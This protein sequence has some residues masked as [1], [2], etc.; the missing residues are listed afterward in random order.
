MKRNYIVL[1]KPEK[2]LTTISTPGTRKFIAKGKS[3]T[4]KGVKQ[5][6]A[7]SMRVESLEASKV[8]DVSAKKD[9]E[10]VIPAMPMK[11]MKPFKVNAPAKPTAQNNTWGVEATLAHKSPFNG[12][13][14][15]VAVLDTGINANHPAFKGVNFITE[16]FTGEGVAD[17]DGHGT[18]C[19]GT[20]CGRDVNGTRIGIAPG[21]TDMLIG[22]VIGNEGGS[23]TSIA[24]AINWALKNQ[25]NVISLSLGI[26]FPG[27]VVELQGEGM[28]TDI[29][30]SK[31]LEGYRANI[32]LFEK[33]AAFVK[34]L[35]LFGSATVLVAAAGNESR[36]EAGEDFEIAVSPPAVSEGFISV[37]ALGL[38][39]KKW[40]VANFSNTGPIIAGPGV[41]IL[42]ADLGTG[43]ESLSGTSMA[44]PHVAGI[45]ALWAQQLAGKKNML[46]GKNL[47]AR[48]LASG[49]LTNLKKG[50]NPIAVGNGMAQAPQTK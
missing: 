49:N 11:L 12:A 46:N 9:V 20:I 16:D 32:L 43:L 38:E 36:R 29:A 4:T 8:K 39:A 24:E 15:R 10:S 5:P 34:S 28:D 18:H 27:F 48:L 31:A 3:T 14:I 1:L 22:K 45:A 17:K 26:D 44:T 21:I 19:A 41:D 25:A 30:T 13:G 47:M 40:V 42:S 6:A 50:F 23:S 35:G 37:G 2:K 33:L 7:M